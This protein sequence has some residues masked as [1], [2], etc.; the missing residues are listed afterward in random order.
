VRPDPTRWQDDPEP[1]P[2]PLIESQSAVLPKPE[3]GNFVPNVLKI[4]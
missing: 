3:P 4:R 2:K 1:K